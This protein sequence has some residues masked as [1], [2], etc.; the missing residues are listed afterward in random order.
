MQANP[1]EAPAAFTADAVL[2]AYEAL[3]A[4]LRP[5]YA[6]IHCGSAAIL[7]ALGLTAE[8]NEI[9]EAAVEA[10]PQLADD[11]EAFNRDKAAEDGALIGLLHALAEACAES[12]SPLLVSLDA[13]WGAIAAS[14]VVTGADTSNDE[15]PLE[16]YLY[17]N[18]DLTGLVGAYWDLQGVLELVFGGPVRDFDFKGSLIEL[19]T[20]AISTA[21]LNKSLRRLSSQSRACF[22]WAHNKIV[23]MLR[24][25]TN[26][27][28]KTLERKLEASGI[29]PHF[30]PAVLEQVKA[31]RVSAEVLNADARRFSPFERSL[32]GVHEQFW[33]LQRAVSQTADHPV[34][35]TFALLLCALAAMLECRPEDID[36]RTST[37]IEGLEELD[38]A[39]FGLALHLAALI[40][41]VEL[42]DSKDETMDVA[43]SFD[44][45]C[46]GAETRCALCIPLTFA[47]NAV[48]AYMNDKEAMDA[49]YA[50][51]GLSQGGA[52][53]LEPSLEALNAFLVLHAPSDSDQP[54]IQKLF[55][56]TSSQSY[57]VG[58][59]SER[60]ASLLIDTLQKMDEENRAI[61]TQNI[62]TM[63]F[64]LSAVLSKPHDEVVKV[65]ED[66]FPGLPSVNPLI[67]LSM[68]VQHAAQ[69]LAL[70]C[71]EAME[72]AHA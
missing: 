12:K 34:R 59:A 13:F 41:G 58:E 14:P 62:V 67:V 40:S 36:A 56:E 70:R 35:F 63:G 50:R 48:F 37:R 11:A 22:A 64:V 57:D 15:D 71:T 54:I 1:T 25:V 2:S 55:A 66:A 61:L 51:L 9:L 7:A 5:L 16:H 10:V 39:H 44:A 18:T 27:D 47:A 19:T 33:S 72:A 30:I 3:P 53:D 6:H 8:G 24:A 17:D 23:S 65:Y 46:G 28:L 42:V 32:D 38:A 21:D 43:R 45:A 69:Q 20:D 26:D 60:Y 68:T 4:E 29:R 31:S 49:L 52:E